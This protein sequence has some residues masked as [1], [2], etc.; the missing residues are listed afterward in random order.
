MEMLLPLLLNITLP[1]SAWTLISLSL[2]L[3]VA[4]TAAMFAIA[5]ALQNPQFQAVAKEEFAALLFT[6]FLL[7]FWLG[8]DV[9]FNAIA[10]GLVMSSLPP[11]M[12]SMAQTGTV[13]SGLS[14]SHLELS[15]ACL[16]VIYEKLKAQYIDLYL[17]EALI[18]FLSTISFP[19]G[20]PLPW[21]NMISFSLAPFTGLVLV[22][23]IHTQV[24]ES[25]SYLITVIWAKQFIIKFARDVVPLMLLPLG[26]VMRAF[27]FF[28]TTGSSIIAL[29]FALYFVLPFAVILSSYLIFDVY[30]PAD[31]V[32]TPLQ[33]S[34]FNSDKSASEWQD[35]LLNGRSQGDKLVQQF[36]APSALEQGTSQAKNADGT[37]NECA[38]NWLRKM[39]CSPINVV[40]KGISA[41]A[42]V[43]STIVTLWKFMMG[44]SGDFFF[45][46]FTNPMMP[47]STSAGLYY[48]LIR[49]VLSISPFII[50]ITVATVFEV[51][52]TVTM[53]RDIALL[54]GGEAELVGLTK[55]I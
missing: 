35:M 26:L 46:A 41:A 42:G 23:N 29:S 27:P 33:S 50:L 37:P 21:G 4:M 10:S 2:G 16:D 19:V 25:I 20:N 3:S 40:K 18:G 15:L 32:Y 11:Q 7:L 47:A 28:R 31:F 34:Y 1:L 44:M 9:T 54:T 22:S 12:Q 53:Y 38:G 5:Y 17:Y 55:V 39:L 8:S 48:F 45:T 52:F 36:S 30:K 14:T 49:E 51:V 6:L 24:V 43:V 13:V